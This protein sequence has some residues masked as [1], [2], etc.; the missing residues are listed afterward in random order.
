MPRGWMR[1]NL[2]CTVFNANRFTIYLQILKYSACSIVFG[3]L[4]TARSYDRILKVARTIADLD[5]SDNI[6]A[7][8]IAEAIRYRTVNLGNQ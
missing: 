1:N 2:A 4:L 7:K 6:Q 8:H 5:G 3:S